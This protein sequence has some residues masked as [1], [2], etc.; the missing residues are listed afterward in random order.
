MQIMKTNTGTADRT[1]RILIAVAILI[2]YIS[3]VVTGTLAY[4]LLAVA[5]IFAITGLVGVCPLY[6]LI[7]ISSCKNK[8]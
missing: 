8:T 1:I 3:N 6:S 4:V 7:G 5:G 2:L